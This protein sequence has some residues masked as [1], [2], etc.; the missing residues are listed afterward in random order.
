MAD[1]KTQS[2]ISIIS[3]DEIELNINP[4]E[5]GI[6][7]AGEIFH[8]ITGEF[9]YCDLAVD[10]KVILSETQLGEILELE[11][12]SI[13]KICNSVIY[14]HSLSNASRTKFNKLKRQA[15]FLSIE[16][17][18]DDTEDDILTFKLL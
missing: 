14:I 18:D 9:M 13:H 11:N 4:E 17:F 15:E 1:F 10:G 2:S 3:L 8:L 6:D 7:S 16:N 12:L 5:N